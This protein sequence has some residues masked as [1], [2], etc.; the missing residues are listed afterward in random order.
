MI[1]ILYIYAEISIKGG[2]D[3]VLVEK[4]NWLVNHGYEVTIVTES[5]MGRPLSFE[6]DNQVRHIDIGLDFN[7]QYSQAPLKRLYTYT[8]LMREYKKRLKQVVH[9]LHPDIVITA[10]G[11]SL[12]LLSNIG[13]TGV[14]VGEAHTTKKHLRSLHLME[15][16]GMLFRALAIYMRWNM[17]RHVSKLDALVLLTQMDAEDWKNIT[18][19]YII[20]NPISFY[21]EKA[22]MLQN[23]QVIMV[24][25]YNDAKGY[26]YLIPAWKKVNQRHPDW[27]LNVYGS[28]ELH[29]EICKWVNERKLS[30]SVILHEPI[31]NIQE[32]YLESSICVLSS[33]YEGFSLVILEAMSCGVPCVSYDS[34]YGPRNIICNGEDGLLIDYLNIQALADGICYLIE[35][36]KFRKRLGENARSNILRF[37]KDNVMKYWDML[38]NKLKEDYDYQ[39]DC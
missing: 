33:R 21:P 20:P 14:K 2:T 29:D 1:H 16:K 35:N 17:C 8:S 23:K 9:E 34:P 5:Q 27:I 13:Y 12:S 10:M 39:K 6:I 7:K 25:R 30:H 36:E 28:G 24:G 26:D 38:F 22:A 3:K 11:R 37:S 19:T 15:Q 31:D 18:K 32:K 4:A